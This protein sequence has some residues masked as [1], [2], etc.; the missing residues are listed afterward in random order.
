MSWLELPLSKQLNRGVGSGEGGR[1]I[2]EEDYVE[3]VSYMAGSG[4]RCEAGG[5]CLEEGRGGS[6][7]AKP[8]AKTRHA[9]Y[10]YLGI[11]PI[12]EHIERL[13]G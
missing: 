9:F 3:V 8:K 5:L 10:Q 12:I 13:G 7:I 6:F 4:S 11:F 2:R 1:G